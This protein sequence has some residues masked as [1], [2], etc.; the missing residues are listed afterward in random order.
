M[1]PKICIEPGRDGGELGLA[2][3]DL[4]PSKTRSAGTRAAGK[5]PHGNVDEQVGLLHASWRFEQHL[6][7]AS[8]KWIDKSRGEFQRSQGSLC[9][10]IKQTVSQHIAIGHLTL[11]DND[12][13]SLVYSVPNTRKGIISERIKRGTTGARNVPVGTKLRG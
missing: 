6:E 9:D 5:A 11:R 3:Q 4:H 10:F 13:P 1:D 7:D 2:H 12:T 8:A